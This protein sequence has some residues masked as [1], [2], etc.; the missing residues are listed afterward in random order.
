MRG[1][2]LVHV[3]STVKT[4]VVPPFLHACVARPVGKAEIV[5]TLAARVAVDKERQRL[6]GK[7]VREEDSPREWSDVQREARAPGETIHMAYLS[8]ICVEQHAN[9]APA[10][11]KYKGRVSFLSR[12]TRSPIRTLTPQCSRTELAPQ[13]T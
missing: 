2:S 4:P 11:L 7:R 10:H 12:E 3:P 9:L 13:A 5:G 1:L 6:Q 8:G